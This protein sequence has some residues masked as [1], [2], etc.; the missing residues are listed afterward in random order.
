MTAVSA[1]LPA[2]ASHPPHE[3]A[4]LSQYRHVRAASEA[5]VADLSDADATV[6]SMWASVP[7][8]IG[9]PS[10]ESDQSISA[11]LSGSREPKRADTSFWFSCRTFTQN[12]PLASMAC[13]DRLTLVGQNSTSGGSRDSAANDWQAKPTGTSSC[14]V[15]ITVMPVQNC[16]STFRNVR[17]SI[18]GFAT[19]I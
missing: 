11:N 16:P 17:G 15:V 1:L 2:T 6:Q 13:Q 3:P 14:T 18:G 8:M 12:L 19:S 4:L 9:D 5:L 10:G 7:S